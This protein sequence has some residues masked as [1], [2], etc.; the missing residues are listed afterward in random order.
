MK[1]K[2]KQK[3]M[4]KPK[5][6]NGQNKLKIP[7]SLEY[8]LIKIEEGLFYLNNQVNIS[9][10]K[11]TVF[12][13]RPGTLVD[14]DKDNLGIMLQSN[15]Y[16]DKDK[17]TKVGTLNV[18]FIFQ[19]EKLSTFKTKDE[20]IF[21]EKNFLYSL[22]NISI[23]TFRGI[24]FEKMRGTPLGQKYFPIITIT[25]VVN[26]TLKSVAVDNYF[27]IPINTKKKT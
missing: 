14:L 15:F 12:D 2:K 27:L 24:L 9:S 26:N 21:I 22:F 3:F 8:R 25:E 5:K 10:T 4:K 20:S 18:A 16:L 6:V 7:V 13:L 19:V 1:I 17:V 11:E 23:G